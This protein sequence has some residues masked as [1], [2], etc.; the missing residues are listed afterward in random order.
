LN[1]YEISPQYSKFSAKIVISMLTK[2]KFFESIVY[3]NSQLIFWGGRE[4]AQEEG[5]ILPKDSS[6]L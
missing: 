5:E 6:K 2:S 3:V 1:V 4:I